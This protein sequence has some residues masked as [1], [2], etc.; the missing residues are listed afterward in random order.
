MDLN[1]GFDDY[2]YK[3]V[4]AYKN[5]TYFDSTNISV[6]KPAIQSRIDKGFHAHNLPEILQNLALYQTP[7]GTELKNTII[8]NRS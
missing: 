3:G 1:A 4:E 2:V 5:L 7:K 8:D 6:V